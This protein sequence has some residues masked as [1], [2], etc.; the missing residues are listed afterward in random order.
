M[1]DAI[2]IEEA[3]IREDIEHNLKL[4]AVDDLETEEEIREGIELINNLGQSFRHVHVDLKTKIPE[5][6][7]TYHDYGEISKK[8]IEYV[9]AAR[10][11][12]KAK[13][14]AEE[15]CQE[16]KER[17][18]KEEEERLRL[19][20]EDEERK[21]LKVEE[22]R[23]NLKIS[24]FENLVDLNTCTNV[25][26]LDEYIITMNNFIKEYYE[27]SGKL[28]VSLGK[29]YLHF[30]E[31]FKQKTEEMGQEIKLAKILRQKLLDVYE[32]NK[33]AE[34]DR[35]K[36]QNQ[37]LRARNLSSEIELRCECLENTFNQDLEGL[38]DY[39]IL[40]ISKDSSYETEFKCVLEKI[41]ELASFV[42]GGHEVQT[43][44]ES[45][46]SKRDI[47]VDKKKAFYKKLQSILVE[48][49]ITPD[50][51]K[52]ASTL[53][54]EIP[55]FSGYDSKMDFYTFKSEFKK[56][57][58]PTIQKKYWA[59]YLKRN[60]LTGMAFTLVEKETEYS[61]IWEILSQSFGN[62]RL[63]LQNKLGDLDKIGGLWKLKDEIKLTGTL[64]RLINIMRDLEALAYEHGIEGQ[65]YEGGGL[66]KIIFMLGDSRHKKF[67]GQNL[68]F[69][70]NKKVEWEKL[71]AFL[72]EE[73]QL[74]EKLALD[75]KTAKLL[76]FG[77]RDEREKDEKS[78]SVRGNYSSQYEGLKCCFCDKD[79]HTVITTAR[80]N[81]IIPYYVC[82]SFVNMS[83][84]DR[85]AKLKAKN[86]CTT[87]I[88]PGA[89][90][91]N[92]HKYYFLN[93]C[94]PH[95]SHQGG[96]KLHVLLCDEH[97]N[98]DE[99]VK[100]FEK[101][102]NKFIT[103][104][105]VPLPQYTKH[106]TCFSEIAAVSKSE[107]T[108]LNVFSDFPVEP[109]ISDSA[110]FQLQTIN[111]D[112]LELNLFFDSGCGDM[113]VKKSA[114]EKLVGTGRAKPLVPGPIVITG[115]GEQKS[116]CED[117]IFSI[118]LP[119]HNGKNAVLSG[120]CLPKITSEFPVYEL[121]NIESH[122]KKKCKTSKRHL[123]K[124]LPKLPSKVGGNTDILIGTK[125]AKY[126]PKLVF[127][128]ETGLGIFE[129]SFVS[130]CGTRGI[131]GGPHEEFS[132]IE[133]SFKGLHVGKSAYHNAVCIVRDMSMLNNN[134]SLLG[135]KS[136]LRI[137]DF[138]APIC[139]TL[140][141]E[142]HI[143]EFEGLKLPS[144]DSD[145]SGS[146]NVGT[147]D[148]GFCFGIEE[149][150]SSGSLSE[151]VSDSLGSCSETSDTKVGV[152]AARRPPKCVKQFDLIERAG[153]EISYRCVD[154]RDCVKCKNGGRVDAV[155]IQEEVEQALIDRSV[156]VDAD[157][158]RTTAVLPFVVNPDS[159][160]G[161]SEPGA[162]K[163]FRAQLKKLNSESNDKIAVLDSEKKLQDLGFVDYFSNLTE[164]QKAAI[165]GG[166]VRH[167]IPWR[168]VFNENSVSTSC[169]LVFDA[170]QP[171]LGG[172]SLNSLLAKGANSMNKLIQIMIRWLTW[173]HAFHT[174]ISK[175]YNVVLLDFHFWRYQLYLWS[176]SLNLND[177]PVWKVIKTLIYGVRSSGN[178]AE[179]GLRRTAE[180][181]KDEFPK[182]YD[183][184]M[185]DTYVD[186]CMSG[187]ESHERTLQVTDELQMILSKGG[188][189]LKGFVMS[190]ED[191]PKIL[192]DDQKSVLV[193]GLRWFPKKDFLMIN[194]KELNF[195]KKIRGKKS[196]ENAGIIPKN[197][198]KRD[199]IS[200][201]SE[202]FDIFGFVAPI[203]GGI[204]LDISDLHQRR[205]DWDDP[206]PS[207]L[208]EIWIANFNLVKEIGNI[209]F[210]RAVIPK[211]AVSLDVETIDTA[212]ATAN[213]ICSAI[214]AR[215]KRKNGEYS[216]QLIFARTKI[217]HDLTVPRAELAAAILNAN[218]GHVVRLSLGKMHKKAW[219]LTDSQVV[220][221]WLN[222]TKSALKM[223]VRN[224][225]VEI[226]RLTDRKDWYYIAS[227]DMIADL[228]TRKGAKIEDV[229]PN[230]SW[231]QGYP[232]MHEAEAQFPIK[233][234]RELVLSTI[235]KNEANKEKVMDD[236]YF[237]K[238]RCLATKYVPNEVGTRYTFSK[239]LLDPNKYRFQTVIRILAL[240]FLFL[241]KIGKKRANVFGFLKKRQFRQERRTKGEYVV[242]QVDST[243]YA[244]K[245][246]VVHL[247]EDIVNAAKSYFFLKATHEVKQFVHPSKY[248]NNSI[249]RDGI[250]YFTGRIL[251]SQEISGKIALSDACVDLSASSFCVPITDALSPVAYAIVSETHWYHPDVSHGGV[252]SILRISQC[253]AFVIG[254][255]ELVKSIA[256][257][258]AK[259]RILHKKGVIAAMGP[260]GEFN[261]CIA[262]PFFY[263]QTDL[264]GPFSAYSPVNKRATL[265]VWFV[266]FCC[267]V[268]GAV[269]CRIM[270]NY[271]ADSFLLAFER[272]GCR[273]G[274]PRTILPDEGSQLV[275]GCQNM[276]ISFSDI[277][278]KLSIE[279]GIEFK[280][281][282]VGAHNVHGKV[283]RKIREIRKS[284]QKTVEKNRLSVL[285][286]ET[287]GQQISNS[288]NN[289]PIGLGNKV[290]MLE[291]LDI[292]T[293]NRLIL[294]RNNHRNPT[295]PL[296]VADDL[297]RIIESNNTVYEV[298]FKEWLT[299]YVPLLI[300]KPKWFSTARNMSVGDVV[301][302]LKSEQEFD[303]QYQYGIV[304]TILESRDGIIRSVKVEYQNHKENTK[305][306]TKRGVRELIVIHQIDEIGI[307]KELHDL[308]NT[309]K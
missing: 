240:V 99:N 262:P 62:A 149:Q 3:K 65:L 89:V 132:K 9:K 26:V 152:H 122:L 33:H 11:K 4:Y 277:K 210:Q 127:Q 25:S 28:E 170:S 120:L 308:A 169:R 163:V 244:H 45:A 199:C 172:C 14:L 142:A 51:L 209:K 276:V 131:V 48:R 257:S 167:F 293:P 58:E 242:S 113:I 97:K 269:D 109:E 192:S 197:L 233:T 307:S 299:S 57:V 265:K 121:G 275:K 98:M 123:L 43:M 27:L 187:S 232:W 175:M 136:E 279:H 101:F 64:A 268:T 107:G 90:K 255:R 274:Y 253:T 212:D 129:S 85:Y 80:G 81:K 260:L 133:R 297:R 96:E 67:R 56:L 177:D 115:V 59:D 301:L 150:L 5:H 145:E 6:K 173:G 30:G 238:L 211:D 73:L 204:K 103:N 50:K 32:E 23:L 220:L 184:I 22:N 143:S 16:E 214:Y 53:K 18:Q 227:K 198:T 288:I 302:F 230:S 304:V 47:V 183:V 178:L 154:C 86:L 281:C 34:S 140:L 75:H 24:Q 88:Y 296:Q 126:F 104:C 84:T 39:Q 54:V 157:K 284:L 162:L 69:S 10:H 114:L 256:K 168:A 60:Y 166:K 272:F 202:V 303:L 250:L 31:K 206:I 306:Q 153:T 278:H 218:T 147:T 271:N 72:K 158:C 217:I 160:L 195:N 294:G 219:K 291:N 83:P 225:V 156:E 38:G 252:E 191:P 87:C 264:C 155:S 213:L 82:E 239:Y 282:P 207:E 236:L 102:K 182:A 151:D 185:H 12:M 273:F 141:D 208:K 15:K 228:G 248:K 231:I 196:L 66:E 201:A 200:K 146:G 203:L 161:P 1:T 245:V 283:E 105:K 251:A 8:S 40:Q 221:H 91:G 258:C 229:G 21:V 171:T 77:K 44:F 181:S 295:A 287:L 176:R 188:F 112:G 7:N 164:E 37:T 94:C 118:C 247:P 216:C 93:F 2:V 285:Q 261:L 249:M 68:N 298:W 19:E 241:Q 193:G 234:I 79:N 35:I 194:I 290:D 119:L 263:C 186:D 110:I 117:G 222:C 61:Q 108:S 223:W 70:G 189:T 180:L 266:V 124:R 309:V 270:E 63:L 52:N 71:L 246:A 243:M 76:G 305:R 205:L 174:D 41:T 42:T 190:G 125:Y 237:D 179:C 259:C 135:W 280:T 224:R 144:S 111:V 46:T 148:A 267:T 139:C 106:I 300:E 78:K 138:D 226:S 36:I 100:L 74:R 235:E 159:R 55:K 95:S 17:V 137:V 49:D 29:G 116:V 289:T 134:L 254:G 165:M 92:K 13:R 130:P 20:V 292:L 286:W 128:T 215:Y